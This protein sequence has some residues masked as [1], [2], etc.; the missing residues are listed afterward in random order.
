VDVP[1]AGGFI[2]CKADLGI[3]VGDE[4][5]VVHFGLNP[6]QPLIALGTLFGQQQ[7]QDKSLPPQIYSG[8]LEGL[9]ALMD[10]S[11]FFRP[12]AD[13]AQWFHGAVLAVIR[14][15]VGGFDPCGFEMFVA[16]G[17]LSDLFE[18]RKL[19]SWLTLVGIG[20]VVGTTKAISRPYSRRRWLE[21]GK[22]KC[23]WKVPQHILRSRFE[24]VRDHGKTSAATLSRGRNADSAEFS[25]L[26]CLAVRT[27]LFFLCNEDASVN[28]FF[29]TYAP[30]SGCIPLI[31]LLGM[32]SKGTYNIQ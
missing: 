5:A 12:T 8:L 27:A 20:H 29:P 6:S 32:Q 11:T 7:K 16:L 24:S 23:L 30:F 10:G 25:S 21:L 14:K 13:A 28:G 18:S 1:H 22:V 31:N 26:N 9:K 4:K 17:C 2:P 3:V 19:P 15:F